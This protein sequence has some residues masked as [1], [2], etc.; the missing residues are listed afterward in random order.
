VGAPFRDRI[1]TKLRIG[2]I[3]PTQVLAVEARAASRRPGTALSSAAGSAP[4]CRRPQDD[5]CG[6]R[7]EYSP[8]RQPSP[9]AQRFPRQMPEEV[10][11]AVHG[12]RACVLP[13]RRRPHRLLRRRRGIRSP[14][15][16]KDS[17]RR[18]DS[19]IGK[20]PASRLRGEA[21]PGS[22]VPAQATTS[23]MPAM[24]CEGGVGD[25]KSS[26][27]GGG[28]RLTVLIDRR[29]ADIL[30]RPYSLTR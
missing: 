25:G 2:G 3:F 17:P 27:F 15:R 11:P 29:D 1:G 4:R 30:G 20:K 23:G 12:D 18:R 13:D 14:R 22:P 8:C 7:G 16:R 28:K 19:A 6:A 10:I 5:C 24:I 9:A 21:F 26:E